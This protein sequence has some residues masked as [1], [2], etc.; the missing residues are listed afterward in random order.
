MSATAVAILSSPGVLLRLL[1]CGLKV[2]HTGA[3]ELGIT[4]QEGEIEKS[5]VDLIAGLGGNLMASEIDKHLQSLSPDQLEASNTHLILF[6]GEVLRAQVEIALADEAFA[7]LALRIKPTALKKLP[8]QWAVF[9]QKGHPDA[10]PLVHQDFIIKLGQILRDGETT[11]VIPP[12][13]LSAFLA[14][15]FQHCLSDIIIKEG[16]H[17]RLAAHLAEHIGP[18]LA[19]GLPTQ[20]PAAVAAF[21]SS[22]L[23]F[24]AEAQS[25]LQRIDTGVWSLQEQVKKV[26]GRQKRQGTKTTKQYKDLKKDIGTLKTITAARLRAHLQEASEKALAKDLAEAEAIQSDWQ[27]RETL[28]QAAEAAHQQRL[29]GI[30]PLILEFARIEGSANATH[31]AKELIRIAEEQGIPEA[32]RYL[33]SQHDGILN[34]VASLKAGIRERL[35]PLL[36][37]AQ[38]AITAGDNAKAETLFR[39]LLKADPTWAEARH[40]FIVFL[41]NTLAMHAQTHATLSLAHS[42]YQEA[43]HHSQ[44]LHDDDPDNLIWQN[45]LAVSYNKL[46]EVALAQGNRQRAGHHFVDAHKLAEKLTQSAPGNTDWL[47]GL[48]V[49]YNRLGNVALTDGNLDQASHLFNEGLMLRNKLAQSDPTNTQ[50]QHDLSASYNNLGNVAVEQG[51]LE[52]AALQYGESNKLAKK[53]THKDPG[54]IQWQHDLAI[55]YHKLGNIAMDQGK[56]DEAAHYYDADFKL[57]KSIAESD[58]GNTQWQRDLAI[59]YGKLGG[60]AKEKRNLDSAV[61][62]FGAALK[63]I[64]DLVKSDPEN[65]QW[66]NDLAISYNKLGQ[67]AAKQG[68]LDQ[69]T[70]FFSE[71]LKLRK[72]L[73]QSDSGNAQW[74]RNLA[75]N[76]EKLGDMSM[77]QND[78]KTAALFFTDACEIRQELAQSERCPPEWRRNL[79]GTFYKLGV[80]H[81]MQQQWKEALA[82]FQR[83][84]TI[85]EGLTTLDPTN[86]TWKID[87]EL[88]RE[89]VQQVREKLGQ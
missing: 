50:W 16:W 4:P 82:L 5:I 6:T 15:W 86:A 27:R 12:G 72:K 48:S 28:R 81:S 40:D 70:H 34:S 64:E 67:V 77:A 46:G 80:V 75:I 52:Q 58:S 37:G 78:F 29:A 84:L 85:S 36:S 62:F 7:K 66:Q 17:L 3:T 2:I 24:H 44:R 73:A 25:Y 8:A 23:R 83:C 41:G 56:L 60:V 22:L 68:K 55:S 89:A 76:F 71:A 19:S 54:N 13:Y 63:L 51:N 88:S 43:L 10:Q 26:E 47:R 14:Q 38:L 45:D 53:L 49:S 69:A 59:S 18:A 35:Q 65:T 33:E 57:I 87:V 74:Q 21:K 79:A 61:S 1:C 42:L 9:V 30:E 39:E 32:L 11:A 31:I 20:H